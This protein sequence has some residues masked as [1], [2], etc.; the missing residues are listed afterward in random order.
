MQ[1]SEFLWASDAWIEQAEQHSGDP[2]AFTSPGVRLDRRKIG[3]A[4]LACSEPGL[5]FVKSLV[6]AAMNDLPGVQL[7]VDQFYAAATY[8]PSRH[9]DVN[10]GGVGLALAA[11]R[12][13]ALPLA[14]SQRRRISALRDQLM[15]RAWR[16]TRPDFGGRPG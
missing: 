15:A 7:S 4:S 9:A 1:G 3:Y 10:L 2:D 8:R 11:D 5:F 13:I 12:V 14:A 16:T 6:R